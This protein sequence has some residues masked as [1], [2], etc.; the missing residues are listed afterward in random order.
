MG[1]MKIAAL[2]LFSLASVALAQSDR[3]KVYVPNNKA[4][5]PQP[6]MTPFGYVV[7]PNTVNVGKII[8]QRLAKKCASVEI[9]PDAGAAAFR[10][11]PIGTRDGVQVRDAKG[12]VVYSA[13]DTKNETK[14]AAEVCAFFSKG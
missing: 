1:G 13:T 3:P 7:M 12:D 2:V 4:T 5:M 9:T 10:V 6:M 14:L 8:R 11:E